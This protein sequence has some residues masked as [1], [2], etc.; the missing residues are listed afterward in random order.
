MANKTSNITGKRQHD[1]AACEECRARKLRCDRVQP[2]CGTCQDLDLICI[3]DPV[4]R[5]R[6]PKKGH[7]QALKSRIASLERQLHQRSVS[8]T[9]DGDGEEIEA[10]MPEPKD[11]IEHL[12]GDDKCYSGTGDDW[13]TDHMDAQPDSMHE[14]HS[15]AMSGHLDALASMDDAVSGDRQSLSSS[16]STSG[17]HQLMASMPL[18][19]PDALT[20]APTSI[21]SYQASI[22][23]QQ[24]S[25]LT[26]PFI[27]SNIPVQM[28]ELER[29]DL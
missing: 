2:R 25:A 24:N 22:D 17:F 21:D 19:P 9:P 29:A 8:Q 7:V 15:I 3:T 1:G 18:I 16:S 13:N 11:T 27:G 10:R 6:G 14:W 20:S 28:T 23:L 4:R 12:M 26:P 5:P